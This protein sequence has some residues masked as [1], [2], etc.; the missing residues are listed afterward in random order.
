MLHPLLKSADSRL[1]TRVRR[2]RTAEWAHVA[3]LAAGL[4]V[5]QAV[6]ANRF[7]T[8]NHEGRILLVAYNRAHLHV[9]ADRAQALRLHTRGVEDGHKVGRLDSHALMRMDVHMIGAK[10]TPGA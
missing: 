7:P 5:V 1:V 6:E 2:V 4:D 3:Q 8:A 10:R 9:H